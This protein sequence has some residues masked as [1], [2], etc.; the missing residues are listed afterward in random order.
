MNKKKIEPSIEITASQEEIKE[1]TL[2]LISD[3]L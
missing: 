1:A 2:N 3:Y